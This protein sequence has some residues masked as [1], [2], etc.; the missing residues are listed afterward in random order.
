MSFEVRTKRGGFIR[1]MFFFLSMLGCMCLAGCSGKEGGN[2]AGDSVG[3]STAQKESDS[4]DNPRELSVVEEALFPEKEGYI[5]GIQF[6]QGEAIQLRCVD[7][8]GASADLYLDRAD[9]SSELLYE[10]LPDVAYDK[11]IHQNQNEWY[12]VQDGS[13]YCIARDSKA[14]GCSLAKRDTQGNVVYKVQLDL[15]VDDICQLAGG[16]VILLLKDNLGDQNSKPRL[17]ELDQGTGAVRELSQIKAERGD[18]I[19]AGEESLLI[20][21]S[22]GGVREVSVQDGS[23]TDIMDFAGTTYGID[24]GKW[25]GWLRDVRVTEDGGVELLWHDNEGKGAKE[26][27]AWKQVDKIPVVMRGFHFNNMWIKDAV[28]AFN[29]SNDTYFISLEEA[30]GDLEDF[31]TQTSVQIAAGG[32]PDLLYGEVLSDYIQGMLDKGGFE[33][34]APYMAASGIK[35]EDYFP[36]A[37]STWRRDGEIYG[38]N[39]TVWTIRYIMDASVLGDGAGEPDIGTLVDALYAY[40]DRAMYMPYYGSREILKMFLEGSEDL[41]G[42][43][44]WEQGSCDFSGELFAK[45]LEA[46]KRYAYDEYQDYPV[47]AEDTYGENLFN[48]LAPSLMEQMGKVQVGILFDDGCYPRQNTTTQILSINANSSQKQGAWEFI[49]FLLGEERQQWLASP[50]YNELPVHRKAF[51]EKIETELKNRKGGGGMTILRVPYTNYVDGKYVTEY[52]EFPLED[53]NGEWV[54]A[55]TQM[56]EETRPLPVRTKPILDI[57]CD[58]AED[59]FNGIKSV[60]EVIRVMENR[61]RLYMNENVIK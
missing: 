59:Y 18:Y 4:R 14:S 56:A 2:S 31:T 52:R 8:A 15:T 47:L 27:L 12:M 45:M 51:Q 41:W 23:G 6:F 46:A 42:M 7:V 34:L 60:E 21:N 44:D 13:V 22:M 40:E 48:F 26:T 32:G 3:G 29:R 61:V 17:G 24:T 10:A 36:I 38:V 30:E 37:F 5:L 28:A 25:K 55:F 20:L 35:E 53:V 49:A 11:T 50:G 33:D 58:E 1:R 39:V 57:I 19:G 43:V 16:N 9:G 54:E